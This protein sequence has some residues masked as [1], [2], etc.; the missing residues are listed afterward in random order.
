MFQKKLLLLFLYL[1]NT[2]SSL[3]QCTIYADLPS[4]LSPCLITSESL[5]PNL[6]LL[7]ENKLLYILELTLGFETN[8]QIIVN[9]RL[10]NITLCLVNSLLLII[11]LHLS[12]YLW[13]LLGLWVLLV[14][15]FSHYSMSWVLIRLSKNYKNNE[16]RNS[17]KLF[18]LL[19]KK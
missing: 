7:T 8:I 17:I 10:P 15:L 14:L 19:P 9:V 2:F 16:C 1:A 4:F 18:H 6:L 3:K 13:V 12:I 5:R 11:Q